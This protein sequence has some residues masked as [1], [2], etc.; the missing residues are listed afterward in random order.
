M[1][2]EINMDKCKELLDKI[3]TTPIRIKIDN[4]IYT[5]IINKYIHLILSIL[6]EQ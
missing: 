4:K 2:G 5:I 3:T 6:I 1:S